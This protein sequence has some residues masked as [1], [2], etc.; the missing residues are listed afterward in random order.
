MRGL[1]ILV[2]VIHNASWVLDPADG[3][4]LEL[5][6]TVTASGWVGVQLF[7]VLSGFLITGILLGTRRSEHYFR[8]FYVRRVLRIFPLYY[9]TLALAFLVAPILADPDWSE[10][11]LQKQVWYWTYLSNWSDPFGHDIHGLPHFWSLAVEEQFY[12][13]WPFIV[14][15]LAPRRLAALCVALIT[16]GP[17]IRLSLH[18]AGLPDL[19]GYEFTIARWDALAGGALLAVLMLDGSGRAWLRTWMKHV[20]GWGLVALAGLVVYSRGLTDQSLSVQVLGQSIF[21]ALGTW[22]VFVGTSPSSQG[23]LVVRDAMTARWLRLLGK[24]SYAI[25]VFHYPIHTIASHYVH[26]AVNGSPNPW[27]VLRWSLYVT[28]VGTLSVL[29]AIA[30]WHLLERPFLDLKERWAP[31]SVRPLPVATVDR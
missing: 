18:L 22:M 31:R 7:F 6:G 10:V 23:E 12:L 16:T 5:L 19:A 17:L 1:A 21:V 29:A 4:L 28:G 13:L 2:V 15:A 26:D 3:F 30:S 8:Y 24:Y 9:A 11:A 14:Y 20:G 25:Y 27:R